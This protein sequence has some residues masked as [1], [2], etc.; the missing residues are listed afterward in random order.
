MWLG[1]AGESEQREMLVAQAADKA[2]T[3]Q[4]EPVGLQLAASAEAGRNRQQAV[5]RDSRHA[6]R[7]A[8]SPIASV[9]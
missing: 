2:G 1:M 8:S 3:R 5:D 7:Q 9:A 6:P 4:S